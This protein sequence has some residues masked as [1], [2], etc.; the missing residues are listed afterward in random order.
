MNPNIHIE[1]NRVSQHENCEEHQD[2]L[3]RLGLENPDQEK[4]HNFDWSDDFL[5][6][7]LGSLVTDDF[8]LER[9]ARLVRP[10][11]FRSDAHQMLCRVILEFYAKYGGRPDKTILRTEL[12]ERIGDLPHKAYYYAAL[13][14]V[15]DAFE[16][17]VE[18]REHTL[19]KMVEFAKTQALRVAYSKTL[20]LFKARKSDK[21]K[22]I[23]AELDKAREVGVEDETAVAWGCADVAEPCHVRYVVG[24]HLQESGLAY[25]VAYSGVGKT[26]IALDMALC[27]A[28]GKPFLN[29]YP[30]EQ[31][32]A[33]Y[34]G[35]EGAAGNKGRVEGW[36]IHNAQHPST[37]GIERSS[38]PFHY[39]PRDFDIGTESRD[40]VKL[41]NRMAD[42]PK[43]VVIDTV[44]NNMRGDECNG[45]DTVAF[46]HGCQTIIAETGATVLCLAHPGHDDD[47][48]MR[49]HS[50]Q[51]PACDSV[52]LLRGDIRN[53]VVAKV[54]K[55]K[56]DDP[57]DAYSIYS[58]KQQIWN[59][60]S[61]TLVCIGRKSATLFNW[62][63]LD[64]KAKAMI[65]LASTLYGLEEFGYADWRRA[66]VDDKLMS[67]PTFDRRCKELRRSAFVLV[68]G[69]GRYRL[70][71]DKLPDV[72]LY[73]T[74][75]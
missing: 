25:L 39:V 1:N 27:V 56:N 73:Q 48:R 53:E 15:C 69:N 51:W 38:I 7:I 35:A 46:L 34:V 62:Q 2:I 18:K 32:A 13:D 71:A 75:G 21:W 74:A 12:E 67:Q 8:F 70:N 29:E 4:A 52:I 60:E 36:L 26:F 17:G 55:Q 20:D 65:G 50:S 11:Y 72:A 30:V 9:A 22:R 3:D 33:I 68:E 14:A 47:S 44:A 64:Q 61:D 16:P 6:R 57:L 5:Q 63:R 49:G 58:D 28:T 40:V 66:V 59:G 42:S 23:Y 37:N 10:E 31:G 24:E 41:I 19:A 45:Q 54:A 43:L